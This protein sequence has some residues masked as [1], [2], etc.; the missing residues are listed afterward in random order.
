MDKFIIIGNGFDLNLGIKSMYTQF[1]EYIL[2]EKD[3]K[4]NEEFYNFNK[5]FVREFK[6]KKLDWCDFETIFEQQM[7][8]INERQDS[9]PV[10]LTKSYLVNQLNNDLRE[11]EIMFSKYLT[12][13]YKN[14]KDNV[15]VN[16]STLNTFY[17]DL[18]KR[19]DSD[20]TVVTFNYTNS[21]R[22][23]LEVL[24]EKSK[25]EPKYISENDIYQ[26]HGSLNN[27]NIIFGGGF[28]GNQLSQRIEVDG[29]TENDKLVRIK[30]D[31]NLFTKREKLLE[32]LNDREDKDFELYIL[33]HSLIGSDFQFLKP[34]IKQA[35]KI[36]LFYYDTD[37]AS[38]LQFI[39]KNLEV[40]I[41]E[42]I[43]LVPFFDIVKNPDSDIVLSNYEEYTIV[44]E[45]FKFPIPE[46]EEKEITDSDES[47]EKPMFSNFEILNNNFVLKKIHQINIE[48][49]VDIDKVIDILKKI[50]INN[51]S[52][53][54]KFSLTINS[55]RNQVNLLKKLLEHPIFERAF[56]EAEK[57]EI[58]NCEL[59]IDNLLEYLDKS[60]KIRQLILVG[61][62]FNSKKEKIHIDCLLN[63]ENF[64]FKDN[65]FKDN[66]LLDIESTKI[67]LNFSYVEIFN[68]ENLIVNERVAN[69]MTHAK[70]VIFEVDRSIEKLTFSNVD[71][72]ELIGSEAN[73]ELP[74]LPTLEI[75]HKISKLTIRSFKIDMLKLSEVFID[76]KHPTN[77]LPNI[78]TIEFSELDSGDHS[79]IIVDIFCDIFKFTPK[80]IVETK[81]YKFSEIYKDHINFEIN[82][83][84]TYNNSELL[85]D[86][87]EKVNNGNLVTSV[88][89][90][91]LNEPD[92]VI[93]KLIKNFSE[94][95]CVPENIVLFAVKS[96]K[97]GEKHQL[98]EA[99]I[100]KQENYEKYKKE[101]DDTITRIKY[102]IA[103]MNAYGILVNNI[104][105]KRAEE[106][107]DE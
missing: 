74:F 43:N 107:H 10:S 53:E 98:G 90:N 61:N 23:I 62:T 44:K 58:M 86:K 51:I 76:D 75:N 64:E 77:L 88:T 16:E 80:L 81:T 3:L 28:T 46:V 1:L 22:D 99:D 67:N 68:N 66:T 24:D 41:S 34:F 40:D 38:K 15:T 31:P 85:K 94:E 37:Y 57:I 36:F 56:E 73:E 70:E 72:L 82:L 59:D 6:G 25:K 30:K 92:R 97:T 96:H 105:E 54:E 69:A 50:D 2:R 83:K 91:S 19:T 32:K 5:L 79:K 87:N 29:S 14:W 8:E 33:G 13:E 104:L 12:K 63:V 60:K 49:G 48:R 17:K 45:M 103:V 55:S 26:I 106:K 42:R 35:K 20:T 27:N 18:F 11:L 84:D 71:R 21:L 39:I 47:R 93:K 100:K 65:I 9:V 89:H 52:F 102:N 95:W 4:S 78:V 7:L 101:K